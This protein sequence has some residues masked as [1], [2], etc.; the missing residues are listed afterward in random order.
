MESRSP[1]QNDSSAGAP[2]TSATVAV[3]SYNAFDADIRIWKQNVKST[4]PFS[5][6]EEEK[7]IRNHD[8]VH[9]P[10]AWATT[11]EGEAHL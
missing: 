11:A 1:N 4:S 2:P 10:G 5:D 8:R 6:D 9:Q 7:V 3:I